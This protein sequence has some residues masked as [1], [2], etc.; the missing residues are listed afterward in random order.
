[1]QSGL[2]WFDSTPGLPLAEKV[3]QGAEHYRTKYGRMP[4]VCYVNAAAL[5]EGEFS[6][7]FHEG[8]LRVVAA[9]NILPHHFWIGAN[10]G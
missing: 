8:R 1:M 3:G 2:L 10:D 5:K 9:S 6:M 7:P 4:D